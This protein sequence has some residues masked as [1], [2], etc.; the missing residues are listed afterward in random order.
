VGA[1][2]K[3]VHLWA[4]PLSELVSGQSEPKASADKRQPS[5]T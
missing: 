2:G 1:K 5:A 4:R 3:L